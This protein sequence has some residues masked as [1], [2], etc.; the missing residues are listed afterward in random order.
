MAKVSACASHSIFMS[1]MISVWSSVPCCFLVLSFSMFLSVVYLFSSTLY[2]H[3]DLNSSFHV[4]SAKA[5]NLCASANRGVLPPGDIPSSHSDLT[6]HPPVVWESRIWKGH[7]S[8]ARNFKVQR[9]A[10]GWICR[11]L[12]VDQEAKLRLKA[13]S[14]ST[15]ARLEPEDWLGSCTISNHIQ[16]LVA[17]STR[18]QHRVNH[19]HQPATLTRILSIMEPSWVE[20]I[21]AINCSKQ[22]LLSRHNRCLKGQTNLG[23]ITGVSYHKNRGVK[24]IIMVRGGGFLQTFHHS[25][26]SVVTALVLVG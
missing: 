26:C 13:T 22:V 8:Y 23:R 10:N 19:V 18:T 25:P 24:Q 21:S 1:S 7:G 5:N 2:L 17:L 9:R 14:T 15:C 12:Q 20:T 6:L 3:S 11:G 16:T 4:D